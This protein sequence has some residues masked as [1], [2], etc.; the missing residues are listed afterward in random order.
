MPCYDKKLEAARD[1]FIF[2]V[3]RE[4]S[5]TDTGQAGPRVTEVDSVLTSGEILDLLEVRLQRGGG[6]LLASKLR[7]SRPMGLLSIA[8]GRVN[9]ERQGRLGAT[10]DTWSEVEAAT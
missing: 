1:D 4:G 10:G 8:A 7:L 3:Q 6:M 2:A 5:D 9:G